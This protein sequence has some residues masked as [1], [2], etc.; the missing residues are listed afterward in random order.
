MEK[1]ICS[2]CKEEKEVCE[3]YIDKTKANG[4]YPSCKKCK[5]NYSETRKDDVKLYLKLWRSKNPNFN[6][7]FHKKNPNYIKE[8]YQNNKEVML[9]R[10]KKHYH[11]NKE[12]HLEKNR[13]RS[14][15]YYKSNRERRLEYRKNYL[16]NNRNKHNEYVK[17]KKLNDPIY[18]LSFIVRNRIRTFLK[19]KNI[20]KKNK[21]F[22]IVGCTPQFLKEHLEK[23]FVDN[24]CWENYGVYGWHI[25][26][27]IPL[28][29]AKTED[30]IYKLCY[31][32]NLQPLWAEDNLKKGSK[33]I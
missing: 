3:F 16:K 9:L 33:L 15:E 14:L 6:K 8:Y 23:Q 21:T 12:K 22:E 28:S 20:T 30:E 18:H 5:K 26:H 10:V 1:K 19:L 4:Y 27:I 24:M 13:K 7:E 2:K 29:S 31:Y 11:E 32:T 17:N 25:D